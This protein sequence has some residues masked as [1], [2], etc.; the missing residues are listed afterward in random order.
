MRD[1]AQGGAD[2]SAGPSRL[3]SWLSPKT[4]IDALAADGLGVFASERFAAGEL[5]AVWGGCV[6]TAS[7]IDHLGAKYCHFATHPYEVA[8]GLYLGSTSLHGIDDAERFNHGC[9]P[10][11]GVQGQIVLLTRREIAEG[12]ELTFD[13]ETTDLRPAPFDCRCGADACRGRI[14][15]SAWRDP[16]HRRRN[17]GWYAWHIER[18][19]TEGV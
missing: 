11:C 14:D 4:R 6:Y 5:V 17:R 3:H 8:S 9:E 1:R 7:E 15:G 13:Y 2:G 19:I 18:R 10:N 12:E 16:D